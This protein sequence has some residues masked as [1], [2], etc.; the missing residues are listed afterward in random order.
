MAF[1]F[2]NIYG[3]TKQEFE[4]AIAY[5]QNKISQMEEDYSINPG[6]KRWF[7]KRYNERVKKLTESYKDLQEV[8]NAAKTAGYVNEN[9]AT[10]NSLTGSSSVDNSQFANMKQTPRKHKWG[11][12][13]RI[14]GAI[15]LPVV[16]TIPLTISAV[17][18]RRRFKAVKN[19]L[20]QENIDMNNFVNETNRSHDAGLGTSPSF[21]EIEMKN[22]LA[23][24]SEIDRLEKLTDP[25]D[26]TLSPAEKTVLVKKLTTLKAYGQNNGY[27]FVTTSPR[28]N[29]EIQALTDTK[30]NTS[31][32]K[33]SAGLSA[34]V[35]PSNLEQ[36]HT[37]VLELKALKTQAES[38]R[39]EGGDNR[40][41]DGLIAKIDADI[42]TYTTQAQVFID[43]GYTSINGQ[44]VAAA[45]ITP[46]PNKTKYNASNVGLDNAYTTVDPQIGTDLATARTY[47]QELGLS[48]DKFDNLKNT[49]D[50]KKAANNAELAKITARETFDNQIIDLETK[51]AAVEA[52]LALWSTSTPTAPDLIVALGEL[53]DISSALAAAKG[54]ADA[55]RSD[56][57]IY[58]AFSNKNSRY[59]HAKD[60]F[61]TY[62]HLLDVNASN[63]DVYANMISI[64]NKPV[65]SIPWNSGDDT[66]SVLLTKKSNIAAAIGIIT[67]TPNI[68]QIMAN[69]GRSPDLTNIKQLADQYL[70]E[71]DERIAYYDK[72]LP[73]YQGLASTN[74]P[75][76]GDSITVLQ[77]K[78]QELE[79]IKATINNDAY[80]SGIEPEVN[81]L[82]SDINRFIG[83]IDV[84]LEPYESLHNDIK[85]KASE[86]AKIAKKL[87]KLLHQGTEM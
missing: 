72:D 55:N 34:I 47:A 6:A 74:K 83:D 54:Y 81:A 46:P 68:D 33:V 49:Y 53:N 44:L 85:S 29:S 22:L 10:L 75:I 20:R 25:A 87:A 66:K 35:A 21:T 51:L 58:N 48:P 18:A 50:S 52:K 1:D 82:V 61:D 60:E 5:Y 69:A 70:R 4:T 62:Q 7:L 19:V 71:I 57:V 8:I 42:G 73:K 12:F 17:R 65:I 32:D 76:A 23:H 86:T 78:R 9:T 37:A 40:M 67:G 24:P 2:G 3:M 31:I 41:I 39:I 26:P 11:Q 79:T 59:I 15:L 16:G 13:F 38:L 43:S 80:K 63:F 56:A 14:L 84:I 27:K 30:F 28:N 77:T 64:T 36:A 45:T